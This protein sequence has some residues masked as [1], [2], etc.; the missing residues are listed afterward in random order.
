M[1]IDKAIRKE[2]AMELT[3]EE[4]QDLCKLPRRYIKASSY[5]PFMKEGFR[6]VVD[7]YETYGRPDDMKEFNLLKELVDEAIGFK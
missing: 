4:R 3:R 2:R 1:V 6:R 5:E 7:D